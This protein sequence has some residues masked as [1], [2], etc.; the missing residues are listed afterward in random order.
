MFLFGAALLMYLAGEV[1]TGNTANGTEMSLIMRP[2]KLPGR[3]SNRLQRG[4]CMKT[5]YERLLADNHRLIAENV[6]LRRVLGLSCAMCSESVDGAP[7]GACCGQ[8]IDE[9][10]IA[11][12][13][14]LLSSSH[15]EKAQDG[16]HE[17]DALTKE[18][19]W[20]TIQ[21][22]RTLVDSDG[23][24][25]LIDDVDA[26]IESYAARAESRHT[27]DL[28]GEFRTLRMGASKLEREQHRQAMTN[29]IDRIEQA[30]MG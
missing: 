28:T 12:I 13:D 17:W 26:H 15:A 29:A 7:G 24:K 19:M 25:R 11:D 22:I 5:E 6:R 1:L 18:E 27:P 2:E 20:E 14:S 8:C 10:G 21:E 9:E 30:V 3:R 23:T 16:P 4:R